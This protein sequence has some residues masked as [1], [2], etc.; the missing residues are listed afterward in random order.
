MLQT[1]ND[2]AINEIYN[3]EFLYPGIIMVENF[4]SQ[5]LKAQGYFYVYASIRLV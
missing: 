2:H 5:S 3:D 1:K 4:Y